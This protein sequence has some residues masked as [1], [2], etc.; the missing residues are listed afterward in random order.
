MFSVLSPGK[1]SGQLMRFT[2]GDRR[3]EY[4]G[5]LFVSCLSAS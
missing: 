1:A 5:H 3:E 2:D 4:I